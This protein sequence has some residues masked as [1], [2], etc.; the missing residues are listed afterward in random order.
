[1]SAEF[2]D[3]LPP[4]DRR[5]PGGINARTKRLRRFAAELKANP[6]KWAKYPEP[7]ASHRSTQTRA[8]QIRTGG[9]ATFPRGEFEAAAR[10]DVL[11]VRAVP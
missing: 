1:M 3:E 6:G 9:G 10:G 8:S 4:D 2:V 7:L 11:Y 5:K